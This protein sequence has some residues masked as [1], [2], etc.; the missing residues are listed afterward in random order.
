MEFR[1]AGCCP[2]V[3]TPTTHP[4]CFVNAVGLNLACNAR[5]FYYRNYL[6]HLAE[7]PSHILLAD[8]KDV[9]FQGD[10]FEGM[11][12]PFLHVAKEPLRLGDCTTNSTWFRKVYGAQ[13]LE[14]H[15]NFP[16]ICS[17]T[18]MGKEAAVRF[19]LDWMCA[20]FAR[21]GPSLDTGSNTLIMDQAIH[22]M[23]CLSHPEALAIEDGETGLI[24][25]LAHFPSFVLDAEGRL[26]NGQGVPFRIVHQY[27]RFRILRSVYKEIHSS[28][29]H[30]D[31]ERT[32]RQFAGTSAKSKVRKSF[33]AVWN[34]ILSL[35]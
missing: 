25:T 9:L 13:A 4:S 14:K 28:K 3:V 26:L 19:Y 34:F 12:D 29:D 35:L 15:Q 23:Y 27:D 24:A 1:N 6:E 30:F 16:V 10:P 31:L 7:K 11:S 18:T 33:K 32:M 5:Y 20:E 17:G 21:H 22:I 2:L 8:L